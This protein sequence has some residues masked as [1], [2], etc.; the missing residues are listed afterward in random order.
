VSKLFNE[1][2][3]QKIR[4]LLENE[5]QKFIDYLFLIKYDTNFV[6]IK[7]KRDKGSD[8]FL[9]NDTVLALYSPETQSLPKFKKKIGDDY[10][11][12]TKNFAQQ[13]KKWMVICNGEITTSM[14]E[15]AIGLK[16]DT[17][18]TNIKGVVILIMSLS[19]TNKRKIAE[20]LDVDERY[21]ANDILEDIISDLLNLP[22]TIKGGVRYTT[23][24]YIE[25]KI[26]KNF[27][28]SDVDAITEEYNTLL[29]Y[30]SSL[31]SLLK[32]LSANGKLD[33]LKS[34]IVSDYSKF[35]GKPNIKLQAMTD[36]YSKKFPT[37][38]EYH[39]YVRVIIVYC[40][41]QCI[42]GEK[43]KGEK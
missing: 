18:F 6:P 19:W 31:K 13:Y 11:K 38:D 41:E 3:E 30:F 43:V 17:I 37:D 42:I 2:I 39:K 27:P 14:Q 32:P 24:N 23:P 8:G 16:K 34:R 15:Y 5:F 4:L 22:T 35:K 9:N 29:R 20:F 36:E 26:Q 21:Y 40:F 33:T 12:Y 7:Q 28:V 10:D 1:I 25:D